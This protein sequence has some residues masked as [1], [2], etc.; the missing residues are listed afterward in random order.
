MSERSVAIYADGDPMRWSPRDIAG[1]G[2]GGA[3]TAVVRVAEGLSTRGYA[4]TVFANVEAEEHAGV[5]Y[6]PR[7]AY[8]GG[9]PRTALISSRSV[10]LFDE[11]HAA[12][13]TLLWM[14]DPRARGL[15]DERESRID[16]M[17]ANSAWH[18]GSLARAHPR[19]AGRVAQIRNGI[20]PAAFDQ[21]VAREPRVLHISQPERGLDVLLE[22]WPQVRERVPGAELAFCHAP[23]YSHIA[24]A[25]ERIAAYRERIAELAAQPGVRALGS[26]SRPDLVH[27]LCSSRVVAVPSW[28]SPWEL[29]FYETSCIAAME[30]QAAGAW[31]VA[32]A[33]GALPETVRTGAL[34]EGEGAPGEPWRSRFTDEL[35]AGLADP[36]RHERAEHGRAAARDLGWD[37]V[38][39]QVD[40]VIEGVLNGRAVA[41]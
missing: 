8:D 29:P 24:A 16:R 38:A 5:A 25:N 3:E 27:L 1:A 34:I 37:E 30:A 20:D 13:A 17:L 41:P 4:V 22:L 23:V 2:A 26:V 15:T 12:E 7:S 39:R 28:S 11:S 14:H 6:S 21:E 40:D 31:V 18:V 32:S 33:W 10:D 9:E 19:I 35:V 36:E